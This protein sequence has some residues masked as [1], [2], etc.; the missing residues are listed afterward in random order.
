MSSN[1]VGRIYRRSRIAISA[2]SGLRYFDLHLLFYMRAEDYLCIT[3]VA[4]EWS[5][6]GMNMA[7]ESM[8]M[9]LSQLIC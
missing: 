7:H 4:P 3:I 5:H 2:C 8:S 9:Y 6:H 1:V